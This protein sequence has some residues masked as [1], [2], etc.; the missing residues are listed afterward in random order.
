ME[1][2]RKLRNHMTHGEKAVWSIVKGRQMNG[3]DFHR[4]KP[5]GNYIADFYCHDLE[6]I[7]EI[8]GITHEQEDVKLNDK[9]KQIY[10]GSIGLNVLRFSDDE[11]L[12]NGNMVAKKIM[13]YVEGFELKA[14]AHTFLNRMQDKKH[15]PLSPLNR[16]DII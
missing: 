14:K 16:G 8:D 2:A 5:I 9:N 13:N 12:G 10:F 1:L 11:V 4:Q 3:Y 6:L 15:T 7:I